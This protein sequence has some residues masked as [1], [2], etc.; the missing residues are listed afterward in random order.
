VSKQWNPKKPTVELRPSRIRR[1]PRLIAPI[2]EKKKVAP[3][4]REQEIWLGVTGIVLFAMAIAVATAGFSLVTGRGGAAAPPPP[5]AQQFLRCGIGDGA[6]CVIDGDTIRFADQPVSI[7]GMEVPRLQTAEC[8]NEAARGSQSAERLTEILN[9][10]KVTLG[11]AV[12]EP[13]G[14]LRRKVEVN[15]QDVATAMIDAGAAREA[16]STLAWC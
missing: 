16:G 6:N 5:P 14:R 8:A 15:G 11:P 10:G 2:E 13:D 4:T 3:I 12:N 7:A 9:S 1:D